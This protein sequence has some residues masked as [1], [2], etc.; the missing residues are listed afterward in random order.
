MYIRAFLV[1][2]PQFCLTIIVTFHS[3]V[4]I[5]AFY[6][7][8]F[9]Q[10]Q[11]VRYRWGWTNPHTNHTLSKTDP[12]SA[13]AREPPSLHAQSAMASFPDSVLVPLN[14]ETWGRIKIAFLLGDISKPD[15]GW[16]YSKYPRWTNWK[17]CGVW[18][19]CFFEISAT[20]N[21]G[22]AH[23]EYAKPIRS[24]RTSDFGCCTFE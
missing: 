23:F 22:S 15:W 11:N 21:W 5:G 20:W 10:C 8:P 2:F 1:Q 7:F 18:R 16:F 19:I 3:V 13:L 9:S 4:Y 24:T 17:I 6:D 14:S 12:G